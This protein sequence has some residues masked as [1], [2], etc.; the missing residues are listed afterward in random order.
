MNSENVIR[1]D[2]LISLEKTIKRYK[3]IWC[4]LNVMRQAACLVVNPSTVNDF[5]SLFNFALVGNASD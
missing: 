5:A 4:N 2:F 3:H 1:A